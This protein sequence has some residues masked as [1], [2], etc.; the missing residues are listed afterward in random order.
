MASRSGKDCLG[1]FDTVCTYTLLRVTVTTGAV[2]A[3]ATAP[4]AFPVA[5]SADGRQLA[6]GTPKGVYVK[7]LPQ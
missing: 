1:L 3:V 6:L 5:L 2:L 7:A 4:D